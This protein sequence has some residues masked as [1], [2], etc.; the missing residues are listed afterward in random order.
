LTHALGS[1]RWDASVKSLV[2]FPQVLTIM[3]ADLE[4]TEQLGY[5][6]ATQQA[7]VLES[8]QRLRRQAQKAGSLKTSEQQRVVV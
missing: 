1:E 4:W 7:A 8:I 3:N 6:M 2:P 5:A